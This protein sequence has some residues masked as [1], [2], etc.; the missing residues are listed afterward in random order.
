[1]N[2]RPNWER[3]KY[4]RGISQLNKRTEQY[5]FE[6]LAEIK[7][8]ILQSP[9][10]KNVLVYEKDRKYEPNNLE[11]LYDFFSPHVRLFLFCWFDLHYV[12]HY[13]VAQSPLE[14]QITKLIN[15]GIRQGHKMEKKDLKPTFN[16]YYANVMAYQKNFTCILQKC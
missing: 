3:A 14:E 4:W 2:I 10:E 1:M 7:S 16:Q 13:S 5:Y 9:N 12:I 15:Q 11:S 6:T 8:M